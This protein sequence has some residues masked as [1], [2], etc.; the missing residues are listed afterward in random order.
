MTNYNLI[1]VLFLFRV[2]A[3][4][5]IPKCSLNTCPI[6]IILL[7]DKFLIR[8]HTF[9]EHKSYIIGWYTNGK[10]LTSTSGFQWHT[11]GSGRIGAP[12]R[13]KSELDF[14]TPEL[15]KVQQRD[16]YYVNTHVRLR[17]VIRMFFCLVLQFTKRKRKLQLKRLKKLE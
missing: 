10:L 6:F 4:N 3:V 15:E 14:L 7:G 17:S 9:Y 13:S 16:Q 12:S 11:G 2:S 5:K 1:T 8:S